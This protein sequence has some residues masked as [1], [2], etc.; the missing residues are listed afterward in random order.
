MHLG[1]WCPRGTWLPPPPAPPASKSSAEQNHSLQMP[2]TL[3]S[4]HRQ[5]EHAAS[6]ESLG[7][8]KHLLPALGPLGR[9]Y[10]DGV[11]AGCCS[12]VHPYPP[13]HCPLS[14]GTGSPG[15]TPSP[16]V[17][18]PGNWPSC[19][20]LRPGALYTGPSHCAGEGGRTVS[21][22]Q[23]PSPTRSFR[24]PALPP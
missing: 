19:S 18:R 6:L 11:G 2:S 16:S 5:A 1:P 9:C 20:C 4:A 14:R 22:A 15:P 8:I 13:P 21:D 24:P 12:E 7:K 23:S 17:P 3:G 10:L